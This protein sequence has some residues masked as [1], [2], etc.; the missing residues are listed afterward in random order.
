MMQ[1]SLLVEALSKTLAGSGMTIIINPGSI[2]AAILAALG[3]YT[4][5]HQAL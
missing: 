5:C 4:R 1:M 3:F 2:I